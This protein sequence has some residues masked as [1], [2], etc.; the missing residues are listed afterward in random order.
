M[1]LLVYGP[2]TTVANWGKGCVQSGTSEKAGL[3]RLGTDGGAAMTPGSDGGC[4]DA[5]GGVLEVDNEL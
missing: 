3:R 5:D 4:S 2:C 1:H